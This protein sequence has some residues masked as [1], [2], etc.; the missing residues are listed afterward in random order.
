MRIAVVASLVTPLL[1]AQAGGAQ[2]FLADL[3]RGLGGRHEVLVFCAAGS[4]L[5]GV[6]LVPIE[7]DREVASA[8]LG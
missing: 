7:V 6:Q 1:E 5:P 2:A 3:A 4:D 8:R